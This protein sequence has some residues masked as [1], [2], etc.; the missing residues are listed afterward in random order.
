MYFLC[1][2]HTK[3]KTNYIEIQNCNVYSS[4]YSSSAL[5]VSMNEVNRKR[6]LYTFSGKNCDWQHN[7]E[8]T[9]K[10][11]NAEPNGMANCIKKLIFIDILSSKAVTFRHLSVANSNC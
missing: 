7:I 6:A 3:H 8:I 4:G 1:V 11:E 10:M 9:L 2:T 5:P